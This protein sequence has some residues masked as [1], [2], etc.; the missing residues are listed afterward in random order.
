VWLQLGLEQRGRFEGYTGLNY[1]P[2]EGD[3]YYL[4]RVRLNAA[5]LPA[6]WIRVAVQ[7]QDSRAAGRR[8]P[9]PANVENPFDVHNAFVDLGKRV[10]NGWSLRVGRQVL[11]YGDERLVGPADWG[12]V[13]RVF[14]AARV[15]Y[16][17]KKTRLE[18]F[19]STVVVNDEDRFDP[20]ELDQQFYG[21][22]ASVSDWSH[23]ATVEPYFF[24][25]RAKSETG[26]SGN[27]GRKQVCTGGL[28][29]NGPL[30][31]R[32]DYTGEIALQTGDVAGDELRAWAGSLTLGRAVG[33]DAR[34]YVEYDHASGDNNRTNGRVGTFDQLYPTN[35]G[36]YGIVDQ[37]GW[38]NMHGIRAGTSMKLYPRWNIQL[39]YHSFW[40]ATKND[41]MYRSNGAIVARNPN[42]TSRHTHQEVDARSTVRASTWLS[43]LFGYSYLIPGEFLKQST[44]GSPMSYAYAAFV[45]TL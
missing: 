5:I 42:A 30:P 19:A 11:S 6:S 16:Q 25:K 2:G 27:I 39:D 24:W 44:S 9:V 22:Y 17:R 29:V 40:L 32:F 38:R 8:K 28:R 43:V 23:G 1:E 10:E 36:K 14:D 7:F 21:L 4:N 34:V 37:M 13:G 15:A 12:N 33:A 35:H 26:E 41:T 20:F 31:N 18:G 45:L 3:A